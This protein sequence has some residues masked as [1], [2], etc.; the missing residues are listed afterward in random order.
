VTGGVSRERVHQL[1][2]SAFL[3]VETGK[4]LYYSKEGESGIAIAKF[5]NTHNNGHK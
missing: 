4:Y 5:E 1:R 2:D 3:S